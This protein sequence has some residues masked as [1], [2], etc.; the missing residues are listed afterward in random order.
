M[1]LSLNCGSLKEPKLQLKSSFLDYDDAVRDK[2]TKIKLLIDDFALSFTYYV[3]TI[4]NIFNFSLTDIIV[5][6]VLLNSNKNKLINEVRK[7]LS[8]LLSH[9][10]YSFERVLL[11][12]NKRQYI[13]LLK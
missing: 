13:H 3:A 5:L 4:E 11:D 12:S 8:F 6:R 2:M 9:R 7:Y 10:N 1:A